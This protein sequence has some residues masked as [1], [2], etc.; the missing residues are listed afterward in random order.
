MP[1]Y[2]YQCSEPECAH[3]ETDVLIMNV[4]NESVEKPICPQCQSEMNR[5]V[6]G[7]YMIH[8]NGKGFYQ[9]DYNNKQYQ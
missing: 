6:G 3:T 9:T 8:F 4:S 7:K 5:V 2:D 1:I